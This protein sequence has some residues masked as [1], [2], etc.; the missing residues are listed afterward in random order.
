MGEKWADNLISAVRY[1]TAETHIEEVRVREDKGEKVGPASTEKRSTVVSRLE[2]GY[3]FATI[4]KSTDET[5]RFGSKVRII[6]VKGTKYIRSDNDETAE[7]NLE[8]LPR[9]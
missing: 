5:W 7:D 3:T 8:E 4:V 1:N 2:S 9:F 6:T